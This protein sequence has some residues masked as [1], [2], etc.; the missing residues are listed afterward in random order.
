M[1][2]HKRHRQTIPNNFSAPGLGPH[3]GWLA[4]YS[5][6]LPRVIEGSAPHHNAQAPWGLEERG[7]VELL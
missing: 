5:C 2:S 3:E 7:V 6:L 4:P 1:L